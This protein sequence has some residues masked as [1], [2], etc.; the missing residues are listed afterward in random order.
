MRI[1][2]LNLY[3]P[4][5]RKITLRRVLAASC[6]DRQRVAVRVLE[7]VTGGQMGS[8]AT[9]FARAVR[10][11]VHA[12]GHPSLPCSRLHVPRTML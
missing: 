12:T 7:L 4:V 8:N 6:S 10:R 11:L 3:S 9:P 2:M 1:V 5:Q